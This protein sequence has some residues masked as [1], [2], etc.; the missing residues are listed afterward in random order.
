MHAFLRHLARM[1]F[2]GAPKVVGTDD[3]GREILTYIEGEVL[4]AG[5]EWRPGVPTPWPSWAR[6]EECLVATARLL[7][8]FH[9]AAASFTPPKLSVWRRYNEPALGAGEAVCHGDIGPHNTVYRDGLPVGFIDWDTIRPNDPVVEFG[10]AA[11]K[12]VPL[13]NDIYFEAS[14]FRTRPALDRRLALFARAYGIH[15]RE[16]VVWALHQAKLRSVDATRYF[17]LTP[18]QAAA[19]LRRVADELEWLA[20]SIVDLVAGLD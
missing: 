9:D 12:Y 6:T 17:P 16:T 8:R 1:G 18:A 10:A 7:R 15:D 20:G 4:A 3:E 19:E 5:P 14:D 11:W 13:G 2:E